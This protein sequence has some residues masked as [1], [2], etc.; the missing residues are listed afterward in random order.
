M[1]Y[2]YMAKKNTVRKVRRKVRGFVAKL[3]PYAMPGGMALGFVPPYMARPEGVI[4]AIKVDIQNF[5]MQAALDRLQ[6]NI[7]G[8]AAP[9]GLGVLLGE[10]RLI[11]KHSR[12]AGDI[13]IG[14]GLGTAAKTF[15]DPP[16]NGTRTA[17]SR[18]ARGGTATA[19][20]LVGLSS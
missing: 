9:I 13:L 4:E 14:F 12:V 19:P 7:G 1:S 18:S 2:E 11:G 6:G 3:R 17:I 10:T 5:E 15:L 20:M 8:I 16:M